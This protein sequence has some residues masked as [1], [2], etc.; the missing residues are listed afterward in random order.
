MNCV[1]LI[2]IEKWRGFKPL[3]SIFTHRF[4]AQMQKP[5]NLWINL[6]YLKLLLEE[7]STFREM[8]RTERRGILRE[9]WPIR[10]MFVLTPL[11]VAYNP[12][13][14][15]DSTHNIPSKNSCCKWFACF[16]GIF[17]AEDFNE[18]PRQN[19]N[20]LR[21]RRGNVGKPVQIFGT[22]HTVKLSPWTW[23]ISFPKTGF[24][25]ISE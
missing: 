20:L 13:F 25:G 2:N 24:V 9:L 22:E 6:R 8:S 16:A 1:Y 19:S 14:F 12:V 5:M 3:V 23:W 17:F 15:G 10:W 11:D 21:Y 4:S 18:V 7:V